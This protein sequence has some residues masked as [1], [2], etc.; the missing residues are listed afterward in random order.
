MGLRCN[1]DGSDELI[2]FFMQHRVPALAASIIPRSQHGAH[3]RL[4]ELVLVYNRAGRL[5]TAGTGKR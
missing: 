1:S 3:L 2:G 5:L 4:D